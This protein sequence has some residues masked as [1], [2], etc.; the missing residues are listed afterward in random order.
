ML[1]L[2]QLISGVFRSLSTKLNYQEYISPYQRLLTKKGFAENID[3]IFP[4][5][6]DN[7]PE[8]LNSHTK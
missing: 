2:R 3:F 8:D 6:R 1:L 5:I 4:V 7:P